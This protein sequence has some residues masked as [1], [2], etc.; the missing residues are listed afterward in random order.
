[1]LGRGGDVV[2]VLAGQAQFRAVALVNYVPQ[3][4]RR[5]RL[6]GAEERVGTVS[7]AERRG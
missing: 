4:L 7:L 1:M 3:L 2:V 5:E 6:R